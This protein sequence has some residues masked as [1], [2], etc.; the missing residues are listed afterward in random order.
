M[1]IEIEGAGDH[2]VEAGIRRLA[3]GSDKVLPRHDAEFG[4]DQDR[5]T[6]L[7]LTVGIAPIGRDEPARPRRQG[8]KGN[9]ILLV[10]LLHTCGFQ[11]FSRTICPKSFQPPPGSA[12]S[13]TRLSS[14]SPGTMRCGDR[15]ST[16]NGP[17]TRVRELSL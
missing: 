12:S 6:A 7:Q 10:R 5:R 9:T 17:A 8:R 16:V 1:R 2:D 11:V 13:W 4:A 15:L 14:A 3:R